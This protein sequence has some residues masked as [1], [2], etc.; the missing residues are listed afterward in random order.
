MPTAGGLVRDLAY[1]LFAP[2]ALFQLHAGHLPASERGLLRLVYESVTWHYRLASVHPSLTYSP[3]SAGWRQRRYHRPA[4]CWLQGLSLDQL[5]ERL[6][7]F[8]VVEGLDLQPRLAT[9]EEFK[10]EFDRIL[11]TGDEH[12]QR[13]LGVLVNP[14]FGFTPAD[15]PVYWRVLALQQRLHNAIVQTTSATIFDESTKASAAQFADSILPPV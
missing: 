2:L 15:R 5:R 12:E 3:E 13:G 6:M 11:R 7:R 14:L 1:D 10:A 4:S 9:R 8:L